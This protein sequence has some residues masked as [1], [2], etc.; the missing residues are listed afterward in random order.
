MSVTE[1]S[2]CENA[3]QLQRTTAV[4]NGVAS[5]LVLRLP[6]SLSDVSTSVSPEVIGM[7]WGRGDASSYI[8][9]GFEH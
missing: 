4:H 9:F 5:R 7:R 6:S 1:T 8:F 3:S 2:D